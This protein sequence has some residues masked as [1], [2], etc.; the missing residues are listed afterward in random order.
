VGSEQSNEVH[1]GDADAKNHGD[2]YTLVPRVLELGAEDD[3]EDVE[4]DRNAGHGDDDGEEDG[5][6]AVGD[7]RNRV[8]GDLTDVVCE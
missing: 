3:E 4:T 1:E 8:D 2:D 7:A 5:V 6:P